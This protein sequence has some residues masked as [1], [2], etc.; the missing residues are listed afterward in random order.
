M[1]D[2][3]S[4]VALW[5]QI[6]DALAGDIASGQFAEGDRLPSEAALAERFGVNRHTVRASIA[7]LVS[8]QLLQSRRGSGTY[9]RKQ[10]K[11]IYPISRRTRFSAATSGQGATRGIT[12]L[13]SLVESASEDVRRALRLGGGAQVERLETISTLD[14]VPIAKATS[15]FDAT[16]FK[17]IGAVLKQTGSITKSLA[18]FGVPD[19]VRA[20]SEVTSRHASQDEIDSLSLSPGAIVLCV[21]SVNEDMS[22]QPIEYG[23]T[24]FAAERTTLQFEP[25]A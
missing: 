25:A 23:Q 16:R 12:V 7:D 5:R 20:L 13:E 14:E 4:G 19:Y 17:G 6:A 2:R 9:I 3:E 8:R 1:M 24:V 11:L 21:T 18:T 22:G 15:R 10:A